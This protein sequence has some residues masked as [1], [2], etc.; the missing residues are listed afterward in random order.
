[1][2]LNSIKQLKS[3]KRVIWNVALIFFPIVL[4]MIE[5]IISHFVRENI[6]ENMVLWIGQIIQLNFIVHL[7]RIKLLDDSSRDSQE[8]SCVFW[9][10]ILWSISQKLYRCKVRHRFY[11]FISYDTSTH[12]N[13]SCQVF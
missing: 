4:I 12:H 6:Q 10:D 5:L 1:M 2:L 3:Y 11:V 8:D 7:C 13:I 9:Q